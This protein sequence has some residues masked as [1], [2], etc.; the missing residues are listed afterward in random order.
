MTD[1]G[2]GVREREI[3]FPPFSENEFSLGN[4]GPSFE[5]VVRNLSVPVG[6]DATF[7]CVVS[8]IGRY[9]VGIRG[10]DFLYK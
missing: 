9:K 1:S 6:R 8:S 10:H 3:I 7:T 5:N 2:K 4:P